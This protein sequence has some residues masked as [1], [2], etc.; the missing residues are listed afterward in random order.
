[1]NFTKNKVMNTKLIASL[2]WYTSEEK[3]SVLMVCIMSWLKPLESLIAD[4][5]GVAIQV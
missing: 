3:L 2:R 1:M 4:V 5:A